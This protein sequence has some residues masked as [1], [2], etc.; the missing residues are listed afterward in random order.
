MMAMSR[1]M[2]EQ[3]PGEIEAL[4]PWRAA[5]TLNARD[6]RRVDDALARDP[7]LARQYAAIQ[8]EY[9]ATIE[10]N[11]SLGGP[12]PRAMQKLFAAIDA[13]PAR[14]AST[15]SG[16]SA[17]FAGFF[18]GLSPQALV[19]SASLA[20]LAL[21]LQAGLIGAMLVWPQTGAFQ[22]ASYQSRPVEAPASRQAE[23]ITRSLGVEPAPRAF[24]RFAPDARA[25]EITALLDRYQA[26]VIDSAKGGIFRLQFGGQSLSKQDTAALI[27]RLQDEKIVSLA[28][29][30]P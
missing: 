3:E 24:V 18:A 5:G 10:L 19:W 21:L 12:S 14:G 7:A 6:T 9:S 13:E 27:N 2:L 17:R 23:P 26:S 11:E 30:A 28:L 15:S 1:K 20:G 16:L 25:A 29:P 4:L 8:E 22:V